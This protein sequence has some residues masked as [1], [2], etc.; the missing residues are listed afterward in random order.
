MTAFGGLDLCSCKRGFFT[1][2][3]CANAAVATC[4]SCSRRICHGAPGAGRTSASSARPSATRSA[5]LDAATA[6]TRR[7]APSATARAGTSSG[8]YDARVLGHVRPVLER[9][10]LP[11]VRRRRAATTTMT[12][13]AGSATPEPLRALWLTETYPPSRGGMAQSCDRIVRGLRRARRARRRPALHAAAARGR[14]WAIEHQAGGRYLACPIEDDPAH[15]LNRAW[16]ALQ[17]E[18]AAD[19]PRRRVRRL[20]ADH[21]RPGL[22]R[23]ARRA[24]D[25]ADPRQRLRRRGVLHPPPPD[26][27]TTR[28]TRSALV[29]AVSRTRSTRSPRCTP[30]CRTCAGSRTG[31]TAPT[32]SSRR[33][34]CAHAHAWRAHARRPARARA[35]RP[36]EGQEGRR[37]PARRA[38]A[39]RRRRPLPPA[40]RGLDGAGHGGVA[41]RARA[42]S[43]T[44]A[45]VPG[46]LRAAAVVRGVRLDRDPVLLRR[47]AERAGRGGGARRADARLARGRDGRRARG[48]RAPRSCSTRATRPAAPGRCSARRGWTRSG[49]ARWARPAGRWRATSS[50]PTL[51]IARYVE[52][53]AQTRAAPA[54]RARDPLLRA[55]RRARPSDPGAQGARRRSAGDVAA[56]RVARSRATRA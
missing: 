42:S 54:A 10:R 30:A 2:R 18:P 43:I 46:P 21:G 22:R 32:G 50:T 4:T 38:A 8:G 34:T 27:S 12:T 24:A 44:D 28:S 15:A 3:D 16:S 49:A 1:L 48:R 53:L 35:V 36:A 19:H 6:S 47:A 39:L 13:A 17:A 40:A 52:A 7:H 31:S 11:L 23:L 51:E 56:H 25:H 5:A 26:R 14:P 55:R 9:H 37:L 29:C 45:A 41:G 20:A 33:A